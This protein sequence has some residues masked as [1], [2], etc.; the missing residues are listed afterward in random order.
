[1]SPE[2]GPSKDTAVQ[3]RLAGAKKS[4][5]EL[6]DGPDDAAVVITAPAV[7]ALEDGFDPA[8]A[9]MQGVLKATGHTGRLFGALAGGE[10]AAAI[11][12]LR[13]R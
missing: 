7:A 1:V 3:V 13:A 2:T 4:D 8:I 10:V 6:V 12:R 11:S 9:Y 5:P